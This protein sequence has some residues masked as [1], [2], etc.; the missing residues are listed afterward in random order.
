VNGEYSPAAV[1]Q[2][3]SPRESHTLTEANGDVVS[4]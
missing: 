4:E 1:G 3:R 2:N